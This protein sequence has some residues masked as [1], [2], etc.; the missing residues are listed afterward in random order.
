VERQ[1]LKFRIFKNSEVSALIKLGGYFMITITVYRSGKPLE[2]ISVS[3]YWGIGNMYGRDGKTNE[4]GEVKLN[5][6]PSQEAK[7]VI[8]Q[9]IVW[10]DRLR[11]NLTFHV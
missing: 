6:D 3:V 11:S 8:N 10:H 2:G 7:V 1:N 4:Y 9:D 5:I